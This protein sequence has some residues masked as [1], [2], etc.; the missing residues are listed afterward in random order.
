MAMLL[1]RHGRGC[2]FRRWVTH[3]V[4][5]APSHISNFKELP[6]I[7]MS[8][9]KSFVSGKQKMRKERTKSTENLIPAFSIRWN[10]AVELKN[11]RLVTV[12]KTT[13]DS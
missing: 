5:T 4:L 6:A 11:F 13:K 10:D 9:G 7:Y 2:R 3:Y 8:G 1:T 12:E